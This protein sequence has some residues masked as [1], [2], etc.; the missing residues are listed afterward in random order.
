MR[1]KLYYP[2]SSINLNGNYYLT[3]KLILN[4]AIH[5]FSNHFVQSSVLAVTREKNEITPAHMN[6]N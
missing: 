5:V 1:E 6:Q 3:L 2:N 4:L